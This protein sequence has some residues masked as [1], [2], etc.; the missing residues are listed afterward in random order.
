MAVRNAIED[1]VGFVISAPSVGEGLNSSVA[2]LLQ[3]P[4]GRFFVK[5]LPTDHRWVWT[6]RRE[7]DVAAHVRPVAP[8]LVAHVVAGG[9]DALIFEALDG[10]HAD[11]R[12][13]SDDLPKVADLVRRVGELSPPPDIELREAAQR[14]AA[15]V[16]H[17]EELW[18]FEGDTLLHTDWNHANVIVGDRARIVD[19]GWAT[20]GAPWLDAGYWTIWLIASGHSP[21]SAERWAA[22]IPAW[23]AAPQAGVTAF[24]AANA[25]LWA[26]IGGDHPDAWT[27][28]MMTASSQ[29]R[30][31]RAAP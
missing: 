30:D 5:A 19:W 11:Y 3:P 22:Q 16:P 4:G 6:Q 28:R 17:E 7:A 10:H 29:W 13:G 31:S 23:R 1:V 25:R 24:A 21:Q 26:E 12:P 20:R 8:A 15:Y 14:L 2:A 9:W 27:H 18:Y